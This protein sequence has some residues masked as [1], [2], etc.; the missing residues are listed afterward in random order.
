MTATAAAAMAT[1]TPGTCTWYV[2]EL[3]PWL[4]GGLG[5]A[6]D[7]LTAARAKGLTTLPATATPQPGD[8][9]VWAPNSGGAYGDGH[10]AY[11]TGV[12]NGMVQVIQ[13]SKARGK[14]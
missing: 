3:A 1:Y 10:T 5:N 13:K 14:R 9:A 6:G 4:P 11:V 2:A 8:V 12:E 7:W